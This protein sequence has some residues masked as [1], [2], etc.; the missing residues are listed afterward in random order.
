[1][2]TNERQYRITRAALREFKEA[3][4]KIRKETTEQDPI[5]RQA[6]IES[7]ES[8]IEILHQQIE[9]YETIRSGRIDNLSVTLNSLG[10]ALALARVAAGLKQSELAEKVGVKPQQI[11]RYE[12]TDYETASLTR[13]NEVAWALGL[14]VNV[15]VSWPS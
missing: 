7:V 6:Q 15:N 3:L 2:I 14:S 13:I 10:E 5:L 12:A 4:S 8:E 1:M 9:Q 11:Q